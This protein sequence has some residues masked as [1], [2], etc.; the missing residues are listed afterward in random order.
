MPIGHHAHQ[1]TCPLAY[2][3]IGQHAHWLTCL[4]ANMPIGLHAHWP[5]CPSAN[6]PISQHAHRPS[7]PSA[8]I[9]IGH[10]AHQQ[11][12]LSSIWASFATF[13]P[14]GL[15]INRLGCFS[16]RKPLSVMI[17]IFIYK[18]TGFMSWALAV[19]ICKN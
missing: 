18:L 19:V 15:L 7:S 5:T 8:I 3:P 6:M 4:S 17:F 1:L 11:S 2:M 9:P 12:C 16:I 13:K 10:Y 14:F